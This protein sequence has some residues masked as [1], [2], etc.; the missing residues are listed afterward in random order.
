MSYK[1]VDAVNQQ[2]PKTVK[3]TEMLI[4]TKFAELVVD[5]KKPFRRVGRDRFRAMTHIAD[6]KT[7]SRNLDALH[8]KG[9]LLCLEDRK[10][11]RKGDEPTLYK[12]HLPEG[13]D[14][15]T[16]NERRGKFYA[17]KLFMPK[18]TED[19]NKF[20]KPPEDLSPV[21]RNDASG[22]IPKTEGKIPLQQGKIPP[23]NISRSKDII[24]NDDD[25]DDDD[26]KAVKK[27]A[28]KATG[29]KSSAFKKCGITAENVPLVRETIK[30]FCAFRKTNTNYKMRTSTGFLITNIKDAIASGT[31]EG[32]F[33]DLPKANDATDENKA[34]VEE[35][36]KMVV[37]KLDLTDAGTDLRLSVRGEF[38]G[39]F[40]KK[41]GN[42]TFDEAALDDICKDVTAATA[43]ERAR[44]LSSGMQKFC[45]S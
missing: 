32:L 6:N 25:D 27:E 11:K 12:L 8:E 2:M 15:A 17:G 37:D 31:T 9:F 10:E 1:L 4:L 5:P 39:K 35:V 22:E 3:P 41:F 45:S 13:F 40:G 18:Y 20:N 14:E 7:I 19:N 29:S 30:G 38:E 34:K 36:W 42:K 33:A 23:S 24:I 21:M 28:A 43:G 26:V 44:E 16:V